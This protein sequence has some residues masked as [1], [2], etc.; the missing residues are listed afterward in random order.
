[1]KRKKIIIF[2]MIALILCAVSAGILWRM[3]PQVTASVITVM[4]M[5]QTGLEQG[6]DFYQQVTRQGSNASQQII[7]KTNPFPSES[8]ADY[9]DV[10]V[11]FQVKNRFFFLLKEFDGMLQTSLDADSNIIYKDTSPFGESVGGFEKKELRVIHLF[12]YRNGLTQKDFEDYLRQ[13]KVKVLCQTASGHVI[14]VNVS[15]KDARIDYM[16]PNY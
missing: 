9:E 8:P 16:K 1:M 12:V 5:D 10:F 7:R 15:L 13:Q 11:D 14:S 6:K 2:M 3:H 4:E